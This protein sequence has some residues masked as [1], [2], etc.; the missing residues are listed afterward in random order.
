MLILSWGLVQIGGLLG[1]SPSRSSRG[2]LALTLVGTVGGLSWL[3]WTALVRGWLGSEVQARTLS[4][5]GSLFE[6]IAHGRPEWAVTFGLMRAFPMGFGVG[7]IPSQEQVS[8]AGS[9]LRKLDIDIESA[10][11]FYDYTFA[12]E[13]RLH[14]VIADF[15]S[16][17]GIIGLL[18]ALLALLTIARGVLDC[19]VQS[20]VQVPVA[21]CFLLIGG[22]WFLLFGPIYSNLGQVVMGTIVACVLRESESSSSRAAYPRIGVDGPEDESEF[23]L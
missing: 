6:V 15:W 7:A 5:G 19:T 20:K 8:I 10:Q 21:W 4:Q 23:V 9:M 1:G 18:V 14:S 2:P 3:G 11:Y 16:H 13:Y 17:F 22:I 12:G